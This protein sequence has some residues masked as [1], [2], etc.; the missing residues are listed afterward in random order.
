MQEQYH[1]KVTRTLIKKNLTITFMESCTSGLLASLFTDTEGASSVF[2][3]SLVTYSNELKIKA[4]VSDK[5]INDYG[6]YSAEC[7]R[8]MAETVQKIYG[9][10]ISVGITGTTGNV[11]PENP[12]SIT[13]S[14][15][16]CIRIRDKNHDFYIREDVKDKSRAQIKSLYAQKVYEKLYELLESV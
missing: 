5:I 12:D 10:N 15:Y 6:V 3:G 8:A 4:G 13:G 1:T 16:F 14:A 2:K 11:D 7:A 9:T